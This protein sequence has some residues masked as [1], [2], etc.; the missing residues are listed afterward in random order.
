MRGRRGA[1]EKRSPGIRCRWAG[2]A[3]AL[4]DHCHILQLTGQRRLSSAVKYKEGI[5]SIPVEPHSACRPA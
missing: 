4:Q 1:R 3:K 2:G 5:G